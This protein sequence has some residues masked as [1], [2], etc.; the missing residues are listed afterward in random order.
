MRDCSR[1]HGSLANLT[2]AL[3]IPQ[4]LFPHPMDYAFTDSK[5]SPI[6]EHAFEALALDEQR[7]PY[8]PT[9]WEEPIG[10][11][12]LKV[13]KQCWFPGVHTNVGGGYEDAGMPTSHL[14]G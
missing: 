1:S 9:V 6:V 11:N 10:P 5:V 14:L 4:V 7:A 2:G 12:R 8:H 3:G 13:L